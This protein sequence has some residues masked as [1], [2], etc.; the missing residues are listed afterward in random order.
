MNIA[1][2]DP[3]LITIIPFIAIIVSII[4]HEIAHGYVAYRCGDM[5]AKLE[6]RLTLNPLP[7]IDPI[8]TLLLPLALRLF[9][10]PVVFGWAKPVP[11][12]Y[13]NLRGG[14]RD[15]FWVAFAGIAVNL[16][17]AALFA[18]I[19]RLLGLA[20]F[21]GADILAYLAFNFVL[22]NILLALFNLMPVPPLDGSRLLRVLL[23]E[24]YK[25]IVD[26][27]EPFGFFLVFMMLIL[28]QDRLGTAV[29]NITLFLIG[30]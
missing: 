21:A 24:Q 17:L 20:T 8:G 10:S 25:G 18:A 11:I 23:P 16:A 1:T 26:Q 5:T 12:N 19:F 7:H 14:E 30:G 4:L 6:G 3:I 13:R 27:I 22:Y 2:L 15:F 9:G 28:L 29:I